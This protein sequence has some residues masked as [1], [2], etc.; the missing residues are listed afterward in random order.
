MVTKRLSFTSTNIYYHF[1]IDTRVDAIQNRGE[2][3][4]MNIVDFQRVL[5]NSTK[6]FSNTQQK[7][8]GVFFLCTTK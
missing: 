5:N 3:R 8:E 1:I 7:I 6:M 4:H 2:A